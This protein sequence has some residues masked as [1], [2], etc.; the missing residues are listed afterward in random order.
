MVSRNL[1]QGIKAIQDGNHEQGARLIK[2]ALREQTLSPENRAMAFVWLA[3]AQQNVEEKIASY[4][5]A[6][7]IAPNN[8]A[9]QQRLNF[10]L[11]QQL[12]PPNTQQG[13]QNNQQGNF[14]QDNRNA[15]PSDNH[16]FGQQT[17]PDFTQFNP[18]QPPQRSGQYQ[19]PP[20]DLWQQN[21]PPQQ[22]QND[23]WQQGAQP[24]PQLPQL[25]LPLPQAKLMEV[26][27]AR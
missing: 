2:I 22:N 17:Q 15:P 7:Q 18:Q 25:P 11:S 24:P 14:W 6:L 13:G 8:E 20:N 9:A 10:Y 3:E 16:Q 19:Q 4:R 26:V 5:S 12:P 23:F 21:T 27:Q 1:D